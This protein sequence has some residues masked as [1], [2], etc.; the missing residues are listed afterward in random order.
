MGLR[1]AAGPAPL[2]AF[3]RSLLAGPRQ[4]RPRPEVLRSEVPRPLPG[5]EIGS[6]PAISSLPMRDSSP[7][8]TVNTSGVA[9]RRVRPTRPSRARCPGNHPPRSSA[10]ADPDKSSRPLGQPNAR[11]LTDAEWSPCMLCLVTS[12]C[13][14]PGPTN[15]RAT[16]DRCAA[17]GASRG[18]RRAK[19]SPPLIGSPAVADLVAYGPPDGAV[20][21]DTSGCPCPD[22]RCQPG[23]SAV[24]HAPDPGGPPP[25]RD[26][27][28]KAPTGGRGRTGVAASDVAEPMWR[29][30][31]PRRPGRPPPRDRCHRAPPPIRAATGPR[32]VGLIPRVTGP[33]RWGRPPDG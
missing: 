30:S 7:L 10:T 8:T 24:S 31:C 26:R 2:T 13:P 9:R 6:S 16:G 28:A 3:G 33:R 5:L 4:P 27:R 1:I 19:R 25:A 23:I 15:D 29:P 17:L 12:S 14:T 18:G 22:T 21:E 11:S 20:G 32:S